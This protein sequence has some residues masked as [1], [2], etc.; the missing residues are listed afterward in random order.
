MNALIKNRFLSLLLALTMVFSI[1]I[2]PEMAYAVSES[3]AIPVG[4]VQAVPAQNTAV[5]PA[6]EAA[7]QTQ[8]ETQSQGSEN[9]DVG[10]KF[11]FRILFV[12]D[13]HGSFSDYRYATLASGTGLARVAT[14][15][16]SRRD[17]KTILIDVGD[18]IQGNATSAFHSKEWDEST[19]NDLSMY[20][21]LAGM[22]YLK[23]DVW[24]MGNHE[25]NFG[26]DR[27][28]KSYGKG[29]T[30]APTRTNDGTRGKTRGI[31][32]FN[33][34][35]SGAI[36][37]GNVFDTKNSDARVWD[38][39]W[40]KKLEN[41]PN[42][43]V[44]GMVH[45]DIMKWDAGN[46]LGAGYRAETCADETKKT[47]AYLKTPEAE[48][49]Y[50]KIDIFIGAQH[51][52]SGSG[53][54]GGYGVINANPEIDLFLGAH[55]HSATNNTSTG[56]RYMEL[57][58]NASSLGQVDITATQQ[59]DGSWKVA[60]RVEDVRF[61][62]V[63]TNA[64]STVDT[65]YRAVV[66]NAHQ[67]ARANTESVIGE[68]TGGPLVNTSVIVRGIN[69]GG[70]NAFYGFDNA[71]THLM[72]N[73][74]QYYANGW[75]T[76][77]NPE[78][79]A[80]YPAGV[81]ISA[82]CP[83]NTNANK[84]PGPITRADVANLYT[85]D[86]NTLCVIE[87]T[88]HQLKL[89]MEWA[90][91][92]GTKTAT[93]ATANNFFK[94]SNISGSYDNMSFDGLTYK[95]DTSMPAWSRVVDMR[96][97]DGTPFDLDA[98][99][100]MAANNH[101]TDSRFLNTGSSYAYSRL[102]ALPESQKLANP[103]GGVFD[104]PVV[105]TRSAQEV[106]TV[107]GVNNNNAEG[108]TGVVG[109]YVERVL[110]GKLTNEI[111]RGWRFD[112]TPYPSSDWVLYDK[113][114]EIVNA[115]IGVDF[116][117]AS[118]ANIRA[119]LNP[120][121]QVLWDSY[122]LNLSL[123]DVKA[124][125]DAE[126]W[127]AFETAV[128]AAGQML[129][130]SGTSANPNPALTQSEVSTAVSVLEAA[131]DA[132]EA[133]VAPPV[134]TEI[135]LL[136][137]NDFHG[138]VDNSASTSN[139]GMARFTAVAKEALKIYP[140]STL[141]AAGD[142]YQGSAISNYF[143]GEPVSK[144]MKELG[145]PYSAL[146]NHDFDWGPAVI[147]KFAE[148]AD[149]GFL[150]ANIFIAGTNQRPDYCKPY[151]TIEL[152]GKK[153]GLVGWAH[154]STPTLVTAAH[155]KG[156][157]FRR[158]T[159]DNW[160]INEVDQWKAAEGWDAVIALTHES[161]SGANLVGHID[162]IILGHTH[163][164]R[165]TNVSGI[166]A[167]EAGYNGRNIGRMKLEFEGDKLVNVSV[168]LLGNVTGTSVL[169]PNTV[170]DDAAKAI[171]DGYYAQ[172]E[173]VFSEQVG[174]FGVAIDNSS[175]MAAW[176][177]QLVYDY[178]QRV[179]GEDDY[180]LL[181]NSGGWRS[182]AYGKT[183]E[184]PVDYWFLNTLM[185]FD[186]EIYLFQLKGE[187]LI[188]LL[189]GRRV[190][191][192]GRV[193]GS[194]VIT[195]AYKV[196]DDWFMRINDQKIEAGKIYKVIMNDFMF[197]GGDNY[198]VVAHG[199]S[200]VLDHDYAIYDYETL[201]LGVPLREAMAQQLRFRS[202]MSGDGFSLIVDEKTVRKGD[203][204]NVTP[205][206]EKPVDSNTAIVTVNYDAAKFE[207]RGFTPAAGVTAINVVNEPGTLSIA[208]MVPDYNTQDYGAILFS[209]KTDA[210]LS[211]E[212]N[213][214]TAMIQ[215]VVKG[216]DGEKVIMTAETE[217]FVYTGGNI[218]TGENGAV[219]LIDLSNVIDLFGTDKTM[220]EWNEKARMYDMNT[221]GI[222]D[223]EDI[224]SIAKMIQMNDGGSLDLAA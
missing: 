93:G 6:P 221:N 172:A 141:L 55:G 11:D 186:N 45:S 198:G 97:A 123:F 85:Y 193:T 202:G 7:A 144:M 113:A 84:Q 206:F 223:I 156:I 126:V 122:A 83:M 148:D 143:S 217:G 134:L 94:T 72:H 107:N 137:F 100:L 168:S 10:D 208:L 191:D 125:C 210:V 182:V 89:L 121:V 35:F 57:A 77:D 69:A 27:L 140:N 183:P 165:T 36:L 215:Y 1:A 130:A 118:P 174:V 110:G 65:A 52:S 224:A 184:Q 169:A 16:N 145:V 115:N 209:A 177:N 39:F 147:P 29:E 180:V 17:D 99:Y 46:T 163:S 133:S 96:N 80:K 219:T 101:T 73:S 2:V 91:G 59:A 152:G 181:Q 175:Q 109:D 176:A 157:E 216:E 196:G 201:I 222:I 32:G 190:D 108:C 150:A 105:H 18:T 75:M 178:V 3:E 119:S 86:N 60:N 42:I 44:I 79:A 30:A 135:N 64:S 142:N 197:T 31:S 53:A 120:I 192:S 188:N 111:D 28:F 104:L 40:V 74:F 20:P 12:S 171:Y 220:P 63:S 187:H 127:G 61:T 106:L 139:P 185:P 92:T 90:N 82:S 33:N 128:K 117:Q 194:P 22:E 189:N 9:A 179:T 76:R 114:V 95:V 24:V 54:N 19:L 25:F 129:L 62:A 203:Y 173:P 68:L 81:T 131:A 151:A 50:G 38:D 167:V 211:N 136:S 47:I 103:E 204:F 195:G 160:F 15:I 13:L 212:L 149:I 71:L 26:M 218:G 56:V 43:A 153:I 207:Y 200:P 154:T 34:R 158:N 205:S 21:V 166:P 159:D 66:E 67:F 88:G 70:T 87:L 155:V 51:I 49:I 102:I 37:G 138:T 146:G 161:L 8:G 213:P 132:V 199:S 78:L 5:S 170:I 58:A 112:G 116:N 98:T 14:A 48:A 164:A 4:A 162:G 23:F 41:G 124:D 214:I